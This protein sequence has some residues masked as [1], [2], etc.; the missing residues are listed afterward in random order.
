MIPGIST[1][2]LNKGEAI[3]HDWRS[4]EKGISDRLT[5]YN[6]TRKAWTRGEYSDYD[7][8]HEE[9]KNLLVK[10]IIKAC[11]LSNKRNCNKQT[12]FIELYLRK[13]KIN[14]EEDYGIKEMRE[15][16]DRIKA[17]LD[18]L[19]PKIIG[20]SLRNKQI[21]GKLKDHNKLK[22]KLIEKTK[23]E[24]FYYDYTTEVESLYFYVNEHMFNHLDNKLDKEKTDYSVK[25][26]PGF[27]F[28]RFNDIEKLIDKRDINYYVKRVM[29]I[30]KIPK[31]ILIVLILIL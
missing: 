29:D 30:L 12:D 17:K 4:S 5:K 11:N 21:G 15:L 28:V 19:T 7:L 26:I 2:V 9:N 27:E 6:N 24:L 1:R 14:L 13:H 18:R 8:K 23:K 31:L 3:T 22:K 16:E 25:S 20:G 10:Y